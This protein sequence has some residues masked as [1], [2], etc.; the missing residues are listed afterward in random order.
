[1]FKKNDELIEKLKDIQPTIRNVQPTKKI[2]PRKWW[3]WPK[4]GRGVIYTDKPP[5]DPRY[6]IK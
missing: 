1:M 2:Y 4:L 6:K 5:R 3:M